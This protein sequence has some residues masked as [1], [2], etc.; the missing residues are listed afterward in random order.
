[1]RLL[2]HES[3]LFS[4]IE[5]GKAEELVLPEINAYRDELSY[6]IQCLHDGVKPEPGLA[7]GRLAVRAGLASYEA[8]AAA[9]LTDIHT[10]LG[11][12][13]DRISTT[14]PWRRQL[15]DSSNYLRGFAPVL[16]DLG[17]RLAIEN[18]GDLTTFELVRLVEEV[19]ADV[20]GICF[21]TGNLFFL[22]AEDPVSATR[23]VA[24]YVRMTHA[25]DA[26]VF[27]DP[28]GLARQI[29]PAGSGCCPWD[30]ML[31]IL[32]GHNPNLNLSIEDHREFPGM[33][34]APAARPIPVC[35]EAWWR[36]AP[37]AHPYE[38]AWLM[39]SAEEARGKMESGDMPPPS[40]YAG[41]WLEKGVQRVRMATDHLRGV[42]KTF[43]LYG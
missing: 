6:F 18:H 32:A 40:A 25:K 23:R 7:E 27:F 8:F 37:D 17:V 9:G 34:D 43:N 30:V 19:G 13:D 11:G 1:M 12:P 16:R 15:R 38:V 22:Y 29:R 21:D 2:L 31:P 26:I 20:L 24:P 14:V 41:P 10:R 36:L 5:D 28:G 3:G 39:R 35:D 42:V 4:N 33:P